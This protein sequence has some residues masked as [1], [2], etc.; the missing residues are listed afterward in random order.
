MSISSLDKISQLNLLL[1]LSK[2]KLVAYNVET[3]SVRPKCYVYLSGE[4]VQIS[5]ASISGN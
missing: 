1:S 3:D 2:I 4:H 5:Q